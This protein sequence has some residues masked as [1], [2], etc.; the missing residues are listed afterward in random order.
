VFISTTPAEL[1][2][3]NG[4]PEYVAVEG[5]PLLHLKNTTATVYR[6]PTDQQLYVRVATG[7]FRAWTTEGP[8]E[9]VSAGD[10]PADLASQGDRADPV[11]GD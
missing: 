10:L 8:W 11:S 7:W 5:T 1:I 2:V 6:E 4:R 9:A 3:T